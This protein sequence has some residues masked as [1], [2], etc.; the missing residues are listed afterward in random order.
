M[1]FSLKCGRTQDGFVLI[2]LARATSR[3]RFVEDSCSFRRCCVRDMGEHSGTHGRLA[4]I[5][6]R[7]TSVCSGVFV[8]DG[9]ILNKR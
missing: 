5:N 9:E 3:N 4:L 6:L 7:V 1:V 8:L 2:R